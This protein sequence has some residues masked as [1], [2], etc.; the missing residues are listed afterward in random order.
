MTSVS[1]G[2]SYR[3]VPWPQRR[4]HVVAVAYL[5]TAE[6]VAGQILHVDGGQSAGH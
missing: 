2:S 6:L 1:A 4:A 5:E 3:S